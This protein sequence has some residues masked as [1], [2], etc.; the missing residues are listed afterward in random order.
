MRTIE[1]IKGLPYV[2]HVDDER[3]HGNGLV[4]SLMEG[5]FFTDNPDCSIRTFKSVTEM[6][7][8]CR[9]TNVFYSEIDIRPRPIS[10][11]YYNY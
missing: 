10:N 11:I 5:W 3:E 6:A 8:F 9:K 2:A 7:A 1:R 4:V